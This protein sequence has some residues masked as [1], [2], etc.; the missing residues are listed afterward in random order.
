M[1]L[2]EIILKWHSFR[3]FAYE[4]S[5]FTRISL[6][7]NME[8]VKQMGSFSTFYNPIRYE[9]MIILDFSITDLGFAGLVLM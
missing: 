5:K 3:Q 6:D 8:V 4:L 2:R 1:M 9:H 7:K